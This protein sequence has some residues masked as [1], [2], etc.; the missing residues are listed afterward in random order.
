MFIRL[1]EIL[2]LLFMRQ[3]FYESVPDLWIIRAKG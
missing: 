2:I 1:S 3:S